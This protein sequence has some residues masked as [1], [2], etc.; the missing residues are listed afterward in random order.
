MTPTSCTEIKR[1]LTRRC[2][3]LGIP[4]SGIFELTPRCNLRCKMCYVRLTPEQMAPLGRELTSEDWISLAKQCKDAGLVFLLLTGGEPTLRKDFP[5]IYE[6][7]ATMGLSLS[8]NTNGTLLTDEIKGLWHRLPPAQVNITIYGVC[9][10]DYEALCGDGSA[11]DRVCEAINWLR[12]EN[13]LVHL[14]TTITPVNYNKWTE[15]EEFA[16]NMGAE[17]RMTGYCFPPTR[18]TDCDSCKE[19]SRLSPEQSG[20]LVALDIFYREGI[21][22][23][24]KRAL[25][26]D[27]PMQRT[28]E[29]DVGDP[30]SCMAGRSQFWLTWHGKLTPCGMLNTP[31]IELTQEGFLPAWEKLK[32]VCANIRLCPECTSCPE[33]KSCMNCAAV[34]FAETGRFDGKPEYMCRLNR[35]LRQTIAKITED[36]PPADK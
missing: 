4:V 27:A 34:T 7:L 19:Y 5:E 36:N 1:V 28:C 32:E 23:I 3:N 14:N 12:K 16:K 25:G 29:L 33:Q 26:L 15:I 24:R 11:F 31:C 8:I 2:A 10:E 6:Q 17:L 30:I 22:G 9:R 21:E 20:E 13:I 35:S 18:R